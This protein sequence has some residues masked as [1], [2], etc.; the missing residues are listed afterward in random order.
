MLRP[1]PRSFSVLGK[2]REEISRYPKTVCSNRNTTSS[3]NLFIQKRKCALVWEFPHLGHLAEFFIKGKKS[4]DQT[5]DTPFPS[6]F[7]AT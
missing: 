5:Q 1:V 6:E 3:C 7:I 2:S 4:N